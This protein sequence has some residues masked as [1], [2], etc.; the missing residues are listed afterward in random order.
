MSPIP[1]VIL[2]NNKSRQDGHP[3]GTNMMICN[4]NT[5]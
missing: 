2:E 3:K 4:Y 5:F 1:G